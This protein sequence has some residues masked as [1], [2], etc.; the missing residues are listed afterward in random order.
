MDADLSIDR[1]CH[2]T[3]MP[4]EEVIAELRRRDHLPTN[5]PSCSYCEA[6]ATYVGHG[7]DADFYCSQC[8]DLAPGAIVEL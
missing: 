4:R 1:I 6:P 8:R 7:E 5:A 3:G 2:E